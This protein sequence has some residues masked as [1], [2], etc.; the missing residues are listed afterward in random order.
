MREFCSSRAIRWHLKWW[1]AYVPLRHMGN[2]WSFRKTG[3]K[4]KFCISRKND[5]ISHKIRI[6][7]RK[8]ERR[9]AMARLL[10][11][12]HNQR[13]G[14]LRLG[15][16][17]PRIIVNINTKHKEQE[18]N[19]LN[20]CLSAG[21]ST[22]YNDWV[23]PKGRNFASILAHTHRFCFIAF[24]YIYCPNQQYSTPGGRQNAHAG[25]S[26]ENYGHKLWPGTCSVLFFIF[27]FPRLLA[28]MYIYIECCYFFF[29]FFSLFI[30]AFCSLD[31]SDR[32]L[33]SF[34]T[35]LC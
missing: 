4:A 25:T 28:Y 1:E 9:N 8:N 15:N 11:R 13:R 32:R 17:R 20:L 14:Y 33:R 27:I 19:F 21:P 10:T 2:A 3:K 7:C 16:N 29:F 30:V 12:R 18:K 26:S 5:L 35:T 34:C 23:S 22:V 24:F 6:I 31:V